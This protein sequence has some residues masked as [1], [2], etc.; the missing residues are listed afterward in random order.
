MKALYII[1]NGFDLHHG[2]P[3][4]Y[5]CFRDHSRDRLECL[6]EFFYFDLD[7]DRMWHNFEE[8][9]GSFDHGI[10]YDH[11]CL[12]DQAES[13]GEAA[14]V[15]DAIEEETDQLVSS[16][17]EAFEG[18]IETIE[19]EST[20]RMMDLPH[21]GIYL[22][23][24]YTG[25][26]QQ[27]YGIPG[28]QIL[29]IH[30]SIEGGHS[31]I[32]GHGQPDLPSEPELDEFGDS[33]RH[34]YSDA[35]AAAK[36]PHHAFKKQV[37]EII[38]ENQAWFDELQSVT[39]IV[40]LGH[41]LNDIDLPYFREIA[42]RAPAAGWVVTYYSDGDQVRH[43]EQLEKAGVEASLVSHCKMG[44]VHQSSRDV[45]CCDVHPKACSK[46]PKDPDRE[47]K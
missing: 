29:H 35:E 14:G 39:A 33:N 44:D 38:N 16:I 40:V 21:D 32:F 12:N 19:L 3:T 46:R 41:S 17:K 4:S 10:F 27:V 9:M 28:T 5:I 23:F 30:G 43:Q 15:A 36:Y 24:N 11:H 7:D 8:Q 31:L 45:P 37:A 34:M 6:E 42:K 26:L 22:S 25:V 18:W 47:R 20:C 13:W 1:G 2:L